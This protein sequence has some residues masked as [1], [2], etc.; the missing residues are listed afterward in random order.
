MS[1]Q[2]TNQQCAYRYTVRQGDSFYLIARRQGVPL[3]DLMEANPGIPPARLM[4][5]DVLCIPPCRNQDC[6]EG[7]TG[8]TSPT[9]PTAPTGPTLPTGPSCPVSP[10]GPTGATGPTGGYVCPA[11]RRAVVQDGQTAGDL[12]IRY[13]VSYHTL[14]VANEG[15]DLENLRGGDIVCVPEENIPCAVPRTVVLKEGET[16]SSLADT[17]G[18]TTGALLKAN[19]CLAPQDFKAGAAVR[20]PE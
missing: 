14:T 18:K 19:P 20:L 15:K 1:D 13:N 2:Q 8:P 4:V 3:R 11:N 16:L 12:Q 6:S 7:P 9:G 10:T 17:Y 5:G